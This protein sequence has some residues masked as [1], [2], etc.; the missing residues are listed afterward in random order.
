MA[1]QGR[2]LDIRYDYLALVAQKYGQIVFADYR[3]DVYR[4]VDRPLP[5]QA[6][7]LCDETFSRPAC[8]VASTPPDTRPGLTDAEV[9]SG[10]VSQSGPACPG[11]TYALSTTTGPGEDSTLVFFTFDQPDPAQGFRYLL[12][13]PGR[14][15]VLHQTAPADA[16]TLT[17]V[18]DTTG[19][20][21][22]VERVSLAV[23]DT[24]LRGSPC[25]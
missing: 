25:P 15:S 5:R 11:A 8:W 1:D 6:V 20:S 10:P 24:S 22:T 14:T 21:A 3:T 19:P 7:P 17:I 12:L 16:K 13:P 4:L 23:A 9:R 18:F 2:S